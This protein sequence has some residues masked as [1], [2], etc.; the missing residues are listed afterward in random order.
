MAS[1][2]LGDEWRFNSYSIHF[3]DSLFYRYKQPLG[4]WI[5]SGFILIRKLKTSIAEHKAEEDD[6][7]QKRE[8]EFTLLPQEKHQGRLK[9]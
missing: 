6:S 8:E 3:T 9:G 2:V 7:N 4:R 1:G 5:P